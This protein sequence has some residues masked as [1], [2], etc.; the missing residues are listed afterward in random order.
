M[1]ILIH[2]DNYW[3]S[4]SRTSN[5]QCFFRIWVQGCSRE[6]QSVRSIFKMALDPENWPVAKEFPQSWGVALAADQ[7]L[8]GLDASLLLSV[9]GA[10]IWIGALHKVQSRDGWSLPTLRIHYLL[11]HDWKTSPSRKVMT[12]LIYFNTLAKHRKCYW[13]FYK[14]CSSNFPVAV[15]DLGCFSFAFGRE[16]AA[17]ETKDCSVARALGSQC[18]FAA[19]LGMF[20]W[21]GLGNPSLVGLVDGNSVDGQLP[22]FSVKDSE[23]FCCANHHQQKCVKPCLVTGRRSMLWRNGM[24]KVQAKSTL[25]KSMPKRNNLA[26]AYFS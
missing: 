26:Q 16:S 23:C 14:D 10:N 7:L 17:S 24:G 6:H 20:G 8:K 13:Q 1:P 5:W 18:Y 3:Q 19:Y 21:D 9:D 12:M 15:A 2:D 11:S 22:E 25:T 4:S